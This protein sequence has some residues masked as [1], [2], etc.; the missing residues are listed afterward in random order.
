MNGLEQIMAKIDN[1]TDVEIERLSADKKADAEKT[2]SQITADAEIIAKKIIA[3]AKKSAAQITENAKSGCESYIKKEKLAAKTDVIGECMEYAQKRIDET[4]TERY[5]KMIETLI[6][7]YAHQESGVL[8]MNSRDKERMPQGFMGNLNAE[9]V[10]SE[11][12][13]DIESGCII[14]YGGIEENC[15]FEALVEEK[16]DEIRDK[17]FKLLKD[18]EGAL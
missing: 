16:R 6:A 18:T 10:L 4:D 9:L 12:N 5:F 8:L 7:R 11:E 3:D 15:T 2:V 13:A 14:R 17:L 1:D